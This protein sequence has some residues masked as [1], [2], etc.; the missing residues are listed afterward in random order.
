M[1]LTSFTYLCFFLAV[2]MLHW[3]LFSKNR[4]FQNA[5]L[6]AA[7]L[8]F[9]ALWD[10]RFLGLLLFSIVSTFL[11]GNSI[12]RSDNR[13]KKGLLLFIALLLNLGVLFVFKYY[14][15]FVTAFIDLFS[16]FG[17]S[18]KASTLKII[19]PV[20]I[21]FFTF[22]SLTYCLDIFKGTVQP[23]KDFLAYCTFIAFF[24]SLL[25]GPINRASKQLPQFLEKRQFSY[26][27]AA[28]AARAILWGAF[29]KLCIADR[30]GV[31]VDAVYD[32]LTKHNGTTLF[33]TQVL[34]SIQIYTDFAGYSLIAIGSGKLLG[35]DLP[36]NF[37]RPYLSKTVTEFWRRWHISLTSWFRDYVY[38]PLGGSKVRKSRWILNILIV[39]AVSGLWHGAAYAFIVWGLL[40]GI[41]MIIERL[42]Y[43]KNLKTIKDSFSLS[44]L[45]RII[46]TFNIVSMIWIFFRLESVNDTVYV[47]SRIFSDPGKPFFDTLTLLIAFISIGILLVKEMTDEYGW[48]IKLLEN[49]NIVIRYASYVFLICFI[50][51]FGEL[52]GSSFIYFKF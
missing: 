39:F 35:I 6:L 28:T 36:E 30:L 1:T 5:L 45:I 15:F 25:S 24:P 27:T 11:I 18:L 38:F 49:K 47:I 22:S 33:M 42:L 3:T 29:I 20:G 8:A 13:K 7:S 32:N 46:I 4:H 40:H 23:T 52:D 41:I 43:G 51:L 26:E 21:S 37:R 31:Y 10:W 50:L 12:S 19:L 16:T 44:N 34:Y 9:Y 17:V 14:N 2:F 48:R